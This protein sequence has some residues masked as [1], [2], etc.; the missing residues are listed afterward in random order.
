MKEESQKDEH[1][2]NTHDRSAAGNKGLVRVLQ[3]ARDDSLQDST[4]RVIVEGN[5][6]D[7]ALKNARAGRVEGTLFD[8]SGE[9]GNFEYVGGISGQNRKLT[10]KYIGD[11]TLRGRING[12][13]AS[14]GGS[15]FAT[16]VKEIANDLVTRVKDA[17]R[18]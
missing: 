11:T 15:I 2:T 10:V 18:K 4:G 5:A 3:D 14:T 8:K 6:Y 16:D 1:I 7:N 9:R 17:Y 13:A 12:M